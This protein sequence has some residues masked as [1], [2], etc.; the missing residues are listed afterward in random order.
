M[1]TKLEQDIDALKRALR[2]LIEEKRDIELNA[3]KER[4]G[5]MRYPE[6][7]GKN[8]QKALRRCERDVGK[9]YDPILE[10]LQ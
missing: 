8:Y 9:I 10:G 3:R 5:R 6:P 2:F 7:R 1:Y 4:A